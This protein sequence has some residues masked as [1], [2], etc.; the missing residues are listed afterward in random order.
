MSWG[1]S[2]SLPRRLNYVKVTLRSSADEY[3]LELIRSNHSVVV[4]HSRTGY[5]PGQNIV[6]DVIERL[7]FAAVLVNME[8]V[9]DLS[10]K[11]PFSL[12]V[13]AINRRVEAFK[14]GF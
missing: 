13:D 11:H 5:V 6:S 14:L 2:R 12:G 10:G 1:C 8:G 9:C 4:E 7:L 3:V